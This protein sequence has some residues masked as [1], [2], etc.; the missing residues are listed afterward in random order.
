MRTNPG[1]VA[2]A[3][4]TLRTVSRKKHAR[5]ALKDLHDPSPKSGPFDDDGDDDDDEEFDINEAPYV[6][7]TPAPNTALT[8]LASTVQRPTA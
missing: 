5:T 6:K 4:K 8:R 3:L 1:L 2:A 7:S